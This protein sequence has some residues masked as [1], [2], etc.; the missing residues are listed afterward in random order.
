MSFRFDVN[1]LSTTMILAA[2]GVFGSSV[3]GGAD[4]SA[5]AQTRPA[6]CYRLSAGNLP[7][8]NSEPESSGEIWC[9]RQLDEPQGA[10]LVYNVDENGE[11][12]PELS[13]M[14]Q[15]DGTLVH[16]SLKKG[17]LTVHKRDAAFS[18][19][20]VPILPPRDAERVPEP[21]SIASA[22][23]IESKIRI[24][25]EHAPSR[26]HSGRVV[27]GKF[28][29]SVPKEDMPWRGYW[30]P[31]SSARMHSSQKSPM[32][33]YDAFIN[34]RAQVVIGAQKWER[35]NHL[36]TGL[37]W[38]GHCNGWAAASVLRPEPKR[39]AVDPYSGIE[40]S[41]SDLKGLWIERDYCPKIAFFGSRNNETERDDPSDIY[42]H[43]FH[44]V[45]T[46]FIGEL[47]K[48]VL[49]D[50]MSTAPVENRVISGYTMDIRRIGPRSFQV[51]AAVKIHEYD[52]QLTEEL[53]DAPHIIRNFRYTL[54][55]DD[56]G[57]I[58]GGSWH[59]ANPD[60]LWV[61]LAPG[62]CKDHNPHV[63]EFWINEILKFQTP[64][65][66]PEVSEGS[67]STPP[68][69]SEGASR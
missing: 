50:L 57:R 44:S 30:F 4:F 3:L 45:L 1:H 34:R 61:A 26:V 58:R 29:A 55:T 23:P 67:E 20:G 6:E 62:N 48:P 46:Y 2:V 38:A 11:T 10:R 49:V 25:W 15:P 52:K 24:F 16:A 69:G 64:E 66:E 8:A 35:H 17:K 59:S 39:P 13:M 22:E 43:D 21:I 65:P 27:E 9:Y 56:D 51:D 18:P 36:Y 42:P 33:K 63:D 47:K 32:S 53:G 5:N 31:H 41:V 54:T 40:F 68:V 37:S 7:F 60:F 14:I 12:R 28:I 19:L